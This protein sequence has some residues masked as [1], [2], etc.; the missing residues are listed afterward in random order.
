LFAANRKGE[1]SIDWRIK[2]LIEVGAKVSYHAQ[3]W[4]VCVTP[5]FPWRTITE[6]CWPGVHHR[7]PTLEESARKSGSMPITRK[8]ERVLGKFVLFW[9]RED[10]LA[11]TGET[12]SGL[13]LGWGVPKPFFTIVAKVA[14]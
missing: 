5:A 3:R 7:L 6:L 10:N 2:R 14:A 12:F 1:R 13:N 9:L 4:Y 11:E 8:K